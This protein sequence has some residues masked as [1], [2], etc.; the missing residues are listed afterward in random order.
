MTSIGYVIG[1]R[2]GAVDA[3]LA[4]VAAVL[5]AQG[6]ALAGVVQVNTE[7]E[8]AIRCDMDLRILGRDETVRI[9]QRLGNAARGCRLDP[10]GLAA[11]VGLVEHSLDGT[12][13]LLV[14][15]FGKSELDGGGFRPVIARALGLGIPVLLG[16]NRDNLTGFLTYAGGMAQAIDADPDA[17][18]AWC[19]GPGGGNC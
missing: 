5:Q 8:G 12:S 10:G 16:I 17:L 7:I 14:N 11:A 9:S 3:L 19:G 18:L 2:R 15:K 4:H 13:L 1:D 6:R